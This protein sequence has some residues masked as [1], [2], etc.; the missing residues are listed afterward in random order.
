MEAWSFKPRMFLFLFFLEP[1]TF[2]LFPP[3]KNCHAFFFGRGRGVQ[4]F[5]CFFFGRLV[6]KKHWSAW[7]YSPAVQKTYDLPF[8]SGLSREAAVSF[9]AKSP[10]SCTGFLV[11]FGE[12]LLA[13]YKPTA[14]HGEGG[15]VYYDVFYNGFVDL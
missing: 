5:M 4:N 8:G 11:T 10:P 2:I 13:S 3:K 9:L 14:L 6:P 7:F 12:A 1:G 15:H